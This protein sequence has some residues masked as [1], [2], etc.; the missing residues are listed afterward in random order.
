MALGNLRAGQVPPFLFFSNHDIYVINIW[1][2]YW[3]LQNITF[4]KMDIY[5]LLHG[6]KAWSMYLWAINLR[7]RKKQT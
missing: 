2:H 3:L 7:L 5:G 6:F 1:V 4:R